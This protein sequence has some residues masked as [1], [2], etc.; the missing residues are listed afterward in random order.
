MPYEFSF[1]I[2]SV[3][4]EHMKPGGYYSDWKFVSTSSKGL[5]LGSYNDI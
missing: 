2:I 3:Y 5:R 4:G 1:G